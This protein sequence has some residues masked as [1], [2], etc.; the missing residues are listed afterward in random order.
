M[1]SQEKRRSR[2]KKERAWKVHNAVIDVCFEELPGSIHWRRCWHI[3]C[4]ITCKFQ[5]K[6]CLIKYSFIFGFCACLSSHKNEKSLLVIELLH[7]QFVSNIIVKVAKASFLFT[8]LVKSWICQIADLFEDN[9]TKRYLTLITWDACKVSSLD[10][11]VK[12]QRI[13]NVPLSGCQHTFVFELFTARN[14]NW[15]F[16]SIQY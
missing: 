9:K 11:R 7:F 14:T 5:L 13:I 16:F 4:K 8:Y 2:S 6:M 3:K 10:S 15:V 12:Y 1:A